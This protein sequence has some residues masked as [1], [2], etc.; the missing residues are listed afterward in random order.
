MM[1][2]Y[3]WVIAGAFMGIVIGIIVVKL[4]NRR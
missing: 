2:V 4:G 1:G 3:E